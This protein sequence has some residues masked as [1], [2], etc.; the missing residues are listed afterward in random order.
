MFLK[1]KNIDSAVTSVKSIQGQKVYSMDG[2]QLAKIKDV[3]VDLSFGKLA[4][5]V[6]Q[7]GGFLGI[8]DKYFAVPWAALLPNPDDGNYILDIDQETIKQTE[9]FDKNNWPDM[10]DYRWGLGIYSHYGIQPYWE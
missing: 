10:A 8:G 2:Q 5:A 4:Y 1:Q 7:F 6:L 9:G 3:M